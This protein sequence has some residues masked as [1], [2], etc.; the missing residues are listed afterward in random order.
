MALLR[1]IFI[2]IIIFY[3]VRLFARYIL[4]SLFVNYMDG[5]MNEF[6]KKQKRH[7]EQARKREG[8]VTID[9]SPNQSKGKPTKGDYVDY[10]EVKEKGN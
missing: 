2:F 9:Y 1:T 6:A 8:E 10:V 5:K 7:Q 3:V 4:P